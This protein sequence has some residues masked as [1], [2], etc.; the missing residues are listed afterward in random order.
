MAGYYR[1]PEAT[2]EVP[3]FGWHRTGDIARSDD[4]GYLLIVDRAKGMIIAG[5]FNVYSTEVEKALIAPSDTRLR[6]RGAAG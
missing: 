6:G 5:E 2:A 4:E 1:N 3:R